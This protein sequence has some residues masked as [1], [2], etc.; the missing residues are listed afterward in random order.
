M[1]T[2]FPRKFRPLS[3]LSMVL[4]GMAYLLRHWVLLLIVALVISPVGPHLLVWYTY[5]DY[6]AYKDMNDCVYL[7]WRGLVERDYGDICPVIMIID[8]RT[9]G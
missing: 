9:E 4:R 5:T 3:W 8:W 7:C 1:K 2:Y 6:G